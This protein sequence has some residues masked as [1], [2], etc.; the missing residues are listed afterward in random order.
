MADTD[1]TRRFR[2]TRPQMATEDPAAYIDARAGRHGTPRQPTTA[3]APRPAP[4]QARQDV[5]DVA[6]FIRK[7]DTERSQGRHAPRPQPMQTILGAFHGSPATQTT[8]QILAAAATAR[9][10][11]GENSTAARK[12][13][14]LAQNNAARL[15]AVRAQQYRQEQT[16]YVEAQLPPEEIDRRIT[17]RLASDHETD[18]RAFDAA[19]ALALSYVAVKS[20]PPFDKLA[21]LSR[22]HLTADETPTPSNDVAS[23]IKEQSPGAQT[24]EVGADTGIDLAKS[25]DVGDTAD[26]IG[27]EVRAE[28]AVEAESDADVSDQLEQV[29]Q[30]AQKTWSDVSKIGSVL[31]SASRGITSAIG[32]V[33]GDDEVAPALSPVDVNQLS[34]ELLSAL[35]AAMS[36]HPRSVTEMLNIERQPDHTNET[37][38]EPDLG[39]ESRQEATVGY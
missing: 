32:P 30:P 20:L 19:G 16:R 18:K 12:W 3:Q 26:E 38:F 15:D 24:E 34:Q 37:V 27:R 8:V 9:H 36:G 28:T 33:N 21:D 6:A 29:T 35:G 13:E 4:A 7:V 17:E 23:S 22:K 5:V 11:G 2:R 39:L 25:P 1:R 14:K 31:E 10:F